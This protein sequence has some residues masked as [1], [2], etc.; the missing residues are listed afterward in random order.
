[1]AREKLKVKRLKLKKGNPHSLSP[2]LVLAMLLLAV[3]FLPKIIHLEAKFIKRK[4]AN[5]RA[6]QVLKLGD[7]LTDTS[8][9]VCFQNVSLLPDYV[10]QG[11]C[12]HQRKVWSPQQK[13]CIGM[14][15]RSLLPFDLYDA[16]TPW[17]IRRAR[18]RACPMP[19][20]SL[21]RTEPAEQ[22][23]LSAIITVHNNVAVAA[24]AILEIVLHSQEVESIEFI[25][26]DDGSTESFAPIA[27][28][29]QKVD[30]YFGINSIILRNKQ[31]VRKC[32]YI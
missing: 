1:M 15:E 26:I 27:S 3:A 11:H 25:V 8:L 21:N 10:S 2:N 31:A 29:L 22:P 7:Y 14:A 24:Q 20:G 6:T 16:M 12:Q 9:S 13:K 32:M 23:D 19:S 30:K 5:I 28:I 4:A 18:P 17:W